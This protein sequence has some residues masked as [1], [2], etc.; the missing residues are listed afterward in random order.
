MGEIKLIKGRFVTIEEYNKIKENK[1]TPHQMNKKNTT[2][3]KLKKIIIVVILGIIDWWKSLETSTRCLMICIWLLCVH[4]AFD[5]I[6]ILD[7]ISHIIIFALFM[8][9]LSNLIA[10]NV[11]NIFFATLQSSLKYN[12]III[13]K[14]KKTK[15]N[16]KEDGN[17]K[18]M[19]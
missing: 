3:K 2:L 5:Q 16:H 17:K 4:R 13:K 11:R 8:M 15:S 12:N 18:E 10:E 9:Y 14:N 6:E 19:I 7:L 1:L